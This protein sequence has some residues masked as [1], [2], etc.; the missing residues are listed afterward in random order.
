MRSA[1]LRF[2]QSILSLSFFLFSAHLPAQTCDCTLAEV[3]SNSVQPC[4]RT[5]GQVDTVYTTN[6]LKSAISAANNAGGNR[7]ILIAD[8]TYGIASTSWYPYITGSNIVFRSLSGNRDNVV[9]HGNGMQDVAPATE[10]GFYCV[11]DNITIADLTIRDCGNHG[12]AMEGDSIFI[13]N[14]R[15]VDV[16]EQL[17]KGTSGGDGSDYSTVQCSQFEYSA[18]IGPNW[19][20]GGLDIHEGS[21]W[22]VHDNLFRDIASPHTSLAE[23]AI[24]FW[25]NSS[26]NLVERNR[27]INCDRGIG[28]GL[29]SS[30]NTGGIIRNNTIYNDGQDPYDDV[31]IGL[32]TSPGTEVYNNTVYIDYPNAIEYRFA[33]TTGVTIENNLTNQA[34]TSRNGGTATVGVNLTS[35]Q[36]TWFVNTAA[37]DLHL[38]GMPQMVV[39]QGTDL[40]AHFSDDIDQGPRPVGG[41]WDIGADETGQAIGIAT[42]LHTVY[43]LWPNPANGHVRIRA[44][45]GST[46]QL[47]ITDLMG[48]RMNVPEQV[49]G[50]IVLNTSRWASGIYLCRF[51]DSAGKQGMHRLWIR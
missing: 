20:I 27:I 2:F 1:Q 4:S 31:G 33:A 13:H 46:F 34:I 10:N 17:V 12:I 42:A 18:G 7:T 38:A 25:D 26:D 36:S 44:V 48:R 30:G 40:S 16:Y 9:L 37:G 5:I 47:E 29:G 51:G 11:G 24:H 43:D 41:G 15:I 35:A 14:V 23:H 3:E 21:G 32:E 45:D 8:G 28:F 22:H 39:D 6:A 19:Y 49:D 50:D